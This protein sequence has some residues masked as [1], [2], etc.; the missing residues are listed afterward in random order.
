MKDKIRF[1]VSITLI[2]IIVMG[3]FYVYRRFTRNA[4]DTLAANKELINILVTASNEY[5]ERRH[6]FYAFFILILK[7]KV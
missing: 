3:L 1:I 5:N 6:S 4:I 2:C 7:K